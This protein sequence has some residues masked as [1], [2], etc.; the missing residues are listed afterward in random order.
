MFI[1]YKQALIVLCMLLTLIVIQ[2]LV[3][4]VAHRR[5]KHYV[6]GIVD[7]QLDH[8]SFVF[9]SHRTFLNSLENAPVFV[10]TILLCMGIGLS[11]EKVFYL[12]LIFTAS[13]FIHMLLFYFIAT[14][15]NPSP[16]SI[17]YMIGLVTQIVALS[18]FYHH[19]FS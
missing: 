17:F 9:R 12:S 7:S 11:S 14:N 5:Q 13:R 19:A 15:K 2:A 6:P 3:A 10:L 18:M 1:D 4:S 8:H 16:R